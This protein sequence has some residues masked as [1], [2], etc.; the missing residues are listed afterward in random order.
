MLLQRSSASGRA[1]CL[2]AK[3]AIAKNNTEGAAML[4]R[5]NRRSQNASSH[6]TERGRGPGLGKEP[7]QVKTV[8]AAGRR[9]IQKDMVSRSLTKA[10]PCRRLG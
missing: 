9:M 4:V 1:F 2:D 6:Q 8:P 7:Q 5:T 10:H 3:A